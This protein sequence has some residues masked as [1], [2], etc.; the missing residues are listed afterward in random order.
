M[1]ART[2]LPKSRASRTRVS[3]ALSTLRPVFEEISTSGRPPHSCARLRPS[4]VSTSLD[5]MILT[6]FFK[7]KIMI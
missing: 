2:S 6:I 4:A 3:K 5:A 1:C 7:R